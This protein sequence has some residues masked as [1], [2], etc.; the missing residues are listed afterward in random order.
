M[1]AVFTDINRS[2]ALREVV[3]VVPNNRGKL[4]HSD[5]TPV[6]WA[7]LPLLELHLSI[8]NW[9][10]LFLR[11]EKIAPITTRLNLARH[12]SS[13]HDPDGKAFPSKVLASRMGGKTSRVALIFPPELERKIIELAAHDHPIC[14]PTL[15]L[16]AWRVKEW[17]QPLLYQTLFFGSSY[18]LKGHLA[19]RAETFASLIQSSTKPPSFFH[20]NHLILSTCSGVENLSIAGIRQR[21]A[22]PALSGLALKRLYCNL[23]DLF[24]SQEKIDFTHGLFVRLTHLDLFYLGTILPST[25]SGLALIPHLSHLSFQDDDYRSHPSAPLTL[26]QTCSALCVLVSLIS[27]KGDHERVDDTSILAYPRFVRMARPHYAA[28]WQIGVHT[29]DDYWVRAEVFIARRISGDIDPT[30]NIAPYTLWV[31]DLFFFSTIQTPQKNPYFRNDLHLLY[32][33]SSHLGCTVSRYLTSPNFFV[34][35]S[36]FNGTSTC[37]SGIPRALKTWD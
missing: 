27:R 35:R 13:H 15:M 16:V 23:D 11:R 1:D 2:V 24:G 22:L 37:D 20:Q 30:S 14:M 12:L 4:P 7:P 26:L 3:T 25:L 28:D 10:L 19:P 9:N 36:S 5:L 18:R 33:R 17:V 21:T 6:S 34:A 32:T 31:I 8:E 29:G